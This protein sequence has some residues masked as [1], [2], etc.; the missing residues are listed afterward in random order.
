MVVS[1]NKIDEFY[2]GIMKEFRD[3]D[4][5]SEIYKN[6][7]SYG[8]DIAKHIIQWAAQDN[9]KHTRSF[10]KYAVANN[11]AS[12]KPTPPAYF[13]AVEPHWNK[14]RTFLIDSAQ[15]FKPLSPTPFSV[16]KNS[17]FYKEALSVRNIG[18][19]LSAE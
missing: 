5:P 14:I 10:S 9:Y 16:E 15:Q 6:S 1:E 2:A 19:N 12:W 17:A 3:S 8:Q 11:T 13:K 4:I 7:V 18:L